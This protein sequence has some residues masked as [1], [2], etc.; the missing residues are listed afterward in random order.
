MKKYSCHVE[1]LPFVV[2]VVLLFFFVG[3]GGNE[4]VFYH[5]ETLVFRC[6]WFVSSIK[7]Y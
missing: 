3:V 7:K 6:L 5:V 1:T 4:E 2:Y